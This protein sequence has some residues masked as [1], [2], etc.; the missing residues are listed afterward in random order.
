MYWIQGGL[1]F[2][3]GILLLFTL[4][5]TI[6]LLHELTHSVV[7]IRNGI[8]VP[9]IVLLPIGGLASV[10]IPQK[11]EKELMI[12]ISG[13]LLNFFIAVLSAILLVLIA[14]ENFLEIFLTSVEKMWDDI[15]SVIFNLPGVLSILIWINLML[16]FF[17]ILPGFP[18]DGGRVF[19]AVLALWMDYVKATEIAVRIGQVIFLGMIF[20]GLFS[21]FWLMIIGMF[22]FFAS[23]SELSMAKIRDSL[24]DLKIATIAIRNFSYVNESMLIQE[25]LK[26]IA[27]PGQSYYPVV[28]TTGKVT[29]VLNTRDLEEVSREK[30]LT[31]SVKDFTKGFDVI[32]GNLKVKEK[33]HDLLSKE[34]LLVVSENK[35]VIGYL[36]PEYVLE[37][38]RFYGISHHHHK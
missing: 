19:R 36:T 24:K 3:F 29:G 25:F 9:S 22:L 27:R 12:A 33:I 4:I 35:Q 14:P 7:A 38:A 11:P 10:E 2:G 37:F 5:F 18:M 21:N 26:L 16:G 34:F 17:N 1:I 6:V 28:D 20:I 30:L 13:P 32:D 31:S 8:K 23:G 15:P